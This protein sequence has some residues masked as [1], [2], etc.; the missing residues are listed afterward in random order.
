MP[1]LIG[2]EK[3][4]DLILSGPPGRRYAGAVQL[5]FLDAVIEGDLRSGAVAYRA[6]SCSRQAK[7]RD[8]PES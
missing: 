5:G 4:L 2:V 8:A 6:R 1:R 7:A 3:A